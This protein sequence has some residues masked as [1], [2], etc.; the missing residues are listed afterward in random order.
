[1]LAVPRVP[2]S[3]EA[4]LCGF[5]L[6]GFIMEVPCLWVQ[7]LLGEYCKFQAKTVHKALNGP[8]FISR[9]DKAETKIHRAV[10][11]SRNS[12]SPVLVRTSAQCCFFCWI[13]VSPFASWRASLEAERWYRLLIGE[14]FS[15][16]P[17]GTLVEAHFLFGFSSCASGKGSPLALP[18]I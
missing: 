4:D 10:I 12:D 1:M 8:F 15:F 16:I 2:A 13:E 14:K 5:K 3:R 6:A 18:V 17:S 9:K 7:G 11:C